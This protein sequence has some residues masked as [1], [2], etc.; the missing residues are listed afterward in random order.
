MNVIKCEVEGCSQEFRSE[1][2]VSKDAKFLCRHHVPQMSA[3]LAPKFQDYQFDPYFPRGEA[4]LV[5]EK[6]VRTDEEEGVVD[7]TRRHIR[8]AQRA[9]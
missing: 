8:A 9:D 2:S 3:D 7:G 4:V 6:N 1:E 5:D